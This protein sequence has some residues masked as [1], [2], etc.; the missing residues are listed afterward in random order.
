MHL[1]LNYYNGIR[2]VLKLASPSSFKV[3]STKEITWV[4]ITSKQFRI[5]LV[6]G[7]ILCTNYHVMKMEASWPMGGCCTDSNVV[8][9]K[10]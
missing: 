3:N 8:G 1:K 5:F 2:A 7:T 9:I 4:K 6:I 10:L